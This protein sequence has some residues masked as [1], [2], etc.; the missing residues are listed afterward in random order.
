MEQ[1]QV[2]EYYSRSEV[3]GEIAEFCRNRW[4]A[5][6]GEGRDGRRLFLRYW[7]SKRTRP[8]TI[9][10]PEDVGRVLE[11][12][13]W[14]KPRAFYAS[15]HKYSE[16]GDSSVLEDHGKLTGS[17]PTW[18]IDGDPQ[19]FRDTLEAARIIV[20]ELG[21]LG[22]TRSV[23]ILWSGRGA[24]VRVHEDALSSSLK[25]KHNPLDAAYALVEYVLRRASGGLQ[26]LAAERPHVKVENL[27]DLKRVFTVPLSLHRELDLC[28]VCF[29]PDEIGE[30]DIRWADPASPRHNPS[31]REFVEG[32]ADEAVKSAL[33]LFPG[34]LRAA[35]PV[36][37]VI[38]EPGRAGV[39]TA[40]RAPTLKVGR[41]QV[42]ALLQAARYYLLFNDE[43][44][45]KSFGLNRAIFYAWA[46]RAGGGVQRRPA[47]TLGTAQRAM[48]RVALVGDEM[49]F[50]SEEG[51]F[52]IGGEVQRP[53]DYDRQVVQKIEAALPYSEAWKKALDYL[54]R[55]DRSVLESQRD[56]YEKVYKPVRDSFLP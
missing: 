11:R 51:W 50:T 39:A 2:S 24:H 36:K 9:S 30:F 14:A 41:F 16:L 47:T 42:M 29:K 27:M 15:A 34:Y 55:F 25:S 19:R 35:G 3:R 40:M 18:D 21:R 46:K 26:R 45:A 32:E 1:A 7:D 52:E 6:E 12:F 53:A 20:E 33:Q 17:T 8:L 54:G 28:A 22:I 49:A 5:V 31:W 23:Y 37:T 44:K 4:L 43:E 48:G 13:L 10:T 38:A 56:F